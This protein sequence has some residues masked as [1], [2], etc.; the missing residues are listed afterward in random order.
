MELWNYGTAFILFCSKK[1][2]SNE[3]FK[4]SGV[5]GFLNKI[6]NPSGLLDGFLR[7]SLI[8]IILCQIILIG[9]V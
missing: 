2:N 6:E 1:K 4:I 8:I 9:S 5:R 3:F 7:I